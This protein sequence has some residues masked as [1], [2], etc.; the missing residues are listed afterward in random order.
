MRYIGEEVIISPTWERSKLIWVTVE[1]WKGPWLYHRNPA[2]WF[3]FEGWL[4]YGLVDYEFNFGEQ[5]DDWVIGESRFNDMKPGK[6][7]FD[8][9]T[10]FKDFTFLKEPVSDIKSFNTIYYKLD[11]DKAN[12]KDNLLE[13]CQFEIDFIKTWNRDRKLNDI[14]L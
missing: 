7:E 12:T 13:Y 3:E 2:F 1:N 5:Y 10:N 14:G 4:Y 6:I 11:W 8:M 9:L